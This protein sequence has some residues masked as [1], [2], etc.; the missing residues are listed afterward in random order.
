MTL[1]REMTE[2]EAAAALEEFLRERPPGLRRMAETL[3][4][5]GHD[6]ELLDGSPESLTPVW[7][8][9]KSKL[10]LKGDPGQVEPPVGAEL[11]SW[12][13]Y[14]MGY[15][16]MLSAGSV[17]VLDGV[18]SYLCEVLERAVPQAQWRVGYD[19]IKSYHWQN[20]PVLALGPAQIDPADF[21]PGRAR[22]HLDGFKESPDDDLTVVARALTAGL[23][24]EAEGA[25]VEDEPLV[26]VDEL[27]GEVHDF[28][29]SVH[30]EVANE[31]SRLVDRL[32]EALGQEQGVSEAL[33]EDRERVLLRAPDWTAQRVEEWATGFLSER[34][35]R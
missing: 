6:P 33:R 14:T 1:Y 11:P 34:L 4:A 27:E 12:Q 29:L 20:H 22:G 8:W 18:I 35:D 25:K 31:H 21:V 9:A 13:R 24:G 15:E 7:R 16:P 23:K 5:D 26:E 28:E 32:V 10:A 2:A 3:R 17:Q 19:R 30:E